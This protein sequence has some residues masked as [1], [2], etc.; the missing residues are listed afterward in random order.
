[1]ISQ[2]F[3]TCTAA[4]I[5]I[6]IIFFFQSERF[7]SRIIQTAF[8]T[9]G[10]KSPEAEISDDELIETLKKLIDERTEFY[11]KIKDLEADVKLAES[12]T[13]KLKKTNGKLRSQVEEVVVSPSVMTKSF[14]SLIEISLKYRI[15]RKCYGPSWS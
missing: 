5:K 1:M 9:P 12:S 3:D 11:K 13:S 15:F 4:K 8:S 14:A 7:H 10:I 2:Y 6:F